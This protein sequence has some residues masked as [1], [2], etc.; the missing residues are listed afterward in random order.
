MAIALT[1]S[2]CIKRE[3]ASRA[4]A[5]ELSRRIEKSAVERDTSV[6][7]QLIDPLEFVRVV[8]KHLGE[9][10]PDDQR[11][12]VMQGVVE[13]RFGEL[14]MKTIGKYGSFKLVREY[15]KEHAA[16]LL[17]REKTAE[18]VNYMD[19][20]LLKK[21]GKV[22]ASDIY[23]YAN[24]ELYSKTIADGI[25]LHPDTIGGKLDEKAE[26]TKKLQNA[27]SMIKKMD[28][29]S[30]KQLI[31]VVSPEYKNS[32]LYRITA[33]RLEAAMNDSVALKPAVKAYVADFPDA[34]D[35]NFVMF[36]ASFK[37]RD[38]N[39]ALEAI[40]RMDHYMGRDPYQDYYRGLAYKMGKNT[41]SA[42]ACFERAYRAEPD[43]SEPYLELM[44]IYLKNDK[45]EDAKAIIKRYKAN[46]T[47]DQSLFLVL[48][49][50]Y[51][52][53]AEYFD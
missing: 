21:N 32:R 9:R 18:G 16:H 13:T 52:Q 41:D 19:Y 3:T 44:V 47:F 38:D 35:V 49:A 26:N 28:Y 15:E 17:F 43:I 2:Q 51:P 50:N 14:I 8:E 23:F 7:N 29:V 48:S 22:V 5:M 42:T 12:G 4:E 27:L 30:A 40:N 6:L 20:T 25:N 39:G 10:L 24:G 33:I 34:Q 53:Y 36:D 37:N 11:K 45:P 46:K 1:F 31:E